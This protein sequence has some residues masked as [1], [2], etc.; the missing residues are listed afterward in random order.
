MMQRSE[1]GR[2]SFVKVSQL[3]AGGIPLSLRAEAPT[4]ESRPSSTLKQ[5]TRRAVLAS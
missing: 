2:R 4:G 1:I 5:V 3:A